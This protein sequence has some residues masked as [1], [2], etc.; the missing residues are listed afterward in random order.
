MQHP[1]TASDLLAT[2]AEVLDDEIVPALKGPVQHH[3]RVAASIVAIIE[4]EL[5]LGPEAEIREQRLLAEILATDPNGGPTPEDPAERRAEVA[6]RLRGGL[7]DDLGTHAEVW[8]RL[9]EIVRADLA[10]A[11]PGYDSWEGR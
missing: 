3:A 8:A 7:A 5:R 4:R 9:C 2:V 11:K 1:P 10:I 6:R